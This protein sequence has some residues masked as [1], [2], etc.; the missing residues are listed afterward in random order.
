MRCQR[1]DLQAV[2][3]V[4]HARHAR[5]VV[6]CEVFLDKSEHNVRVNQ[7]RTPQIADVGTE[8]PDQK[9]KIEVEDS[10]PEVGNAAAAQC[11]C[12]EFFKVHA[13]VCLKIVFEPNPES[14]QIRFRRRAND[15]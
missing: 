2:L 14:A 3:V 9:R 15:R 1:V 10:A 7:V 6:L 8:P 4:R 11:A 5:D 13:V 12:H